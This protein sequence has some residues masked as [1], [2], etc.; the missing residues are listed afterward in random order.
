LFLQAYSEKM[1][2][3][4]GIVNLVAKYAKHGWTLRRVLLSEKSFADLSN[5]VK[6]QFPDAESLPHEIDAVW[7]S[8]KNNDS[9]TWELRRLGSSPFA[10]VEVLEDTISV[11][12]REAKLASLELE[13]AKPRPSPS[14]H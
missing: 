12:E 3:I 8:R 9:E 6:T 7:F 5:S 14:E 10:L 4:D 2:E 13:M 11:D 1:I